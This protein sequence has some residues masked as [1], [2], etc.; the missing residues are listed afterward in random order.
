MKLWF[1]TNRKLVNFLKT[2][3]NRE[4]YI[5]ASWKWFWPR[6]VLRRNF[7]IGAIVCVN[8]IA[9]AIV[10][11]TRMLPQSLKI[12]WQFSDPQNWFFLT[13]K[14]GGIANFVNFDARDFKIASHIPTIV[15][16]PKLRKFCVLCQ[17]AHAVFFK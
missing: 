4:C 3:I 8:L 6:M 1:S 14:W 2:A 10:C 17:F 16:I 15:V 7:N 5:V 11:V 9:G 13:E 12:I